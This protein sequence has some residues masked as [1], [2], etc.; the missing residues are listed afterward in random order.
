[1]D[2]LVEP[3]GSVTV[4]A[5]TGDLDGSTAP[6]A[7]IEVLPLMGPGCRILLDMTGV[8]YMSSAGAADAAAYLPANH[9][10]QRRDRAGRAEYRDRRHDVCYRLPRFL[11]RSHD[12]RRG[13]RTLKGLT[14]HD[15]SNGSTSIQPTTHE[16]FQLRAGRQLPFG[17]SAVPGGV[18][19]S[20]FSSHATSCT[21]VLFEKGAHEAAGR[22]PFPGR[23]PHRQRVCHDRLRPGLR[24]HR[25]W[26]PHGRPVRS[27]PAATASIKTK[28]LLDPYAKAIGGRDVWGKTPDWNDSY[29][30]RARLVY[31]RLRLGGRPPARNARSKTW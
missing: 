18:N 6:Q 11:Q 1:M 27:R 20:I 29:Q 5:L 10:Q 13:T 21:L 26:L 31:R 24:E 17:A 25:V 19:F 28:I 30:H 16:S 22:D 4:V 2:I 15:W 12:G 7:Q 23:V 9:A 3:V 14:A 8:D